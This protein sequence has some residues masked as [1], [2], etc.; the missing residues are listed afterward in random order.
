MI[1]RRS[2][3]HRLKR[4][5]PK[6]KERLANTLASQAAAPQGAVKVLYLSKIEENC[7]DGRFARLHSAEAHT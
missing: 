4:Y 7:D 5:E 3:T 2:E 1:I 6:L